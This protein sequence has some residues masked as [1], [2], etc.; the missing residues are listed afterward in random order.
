M[1]GALDYRTVFR[2]FADGHAVESIISGWQISEERLA[3]LLT[4][5]H[6]SGLEVQT[7][8]LVPGKLHDRVVEAIVERPDLGP[9]EISGRFQ[10]KLSPA[11]ARVVKLIIGDRRGQ[12][13]RVFTED[14]FAETLREDLAS[15]RREILFVTS[16][17]KGKQWREYAGAVRRLVG[18]EGQVGLFTKSI[19]SIIEDDVRDTGFIVI[20]K[21]THANFIMIDGRLLW[22]GSMNFL[23]PPE[24]EEHVRRTESLLLC[25]EIRDLHD[26]YL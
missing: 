4:Q 24:G 1:S 20:E 22:E 6:H 19:S 11:L 7:P 25:D 21:H 16:Q 12:H 2:L 23:L 3:E 18:L 17:V 14:G 13:T 8:W 5:G 15:A 10:G 26:L 9:V